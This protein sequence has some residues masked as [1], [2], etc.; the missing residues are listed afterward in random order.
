M[1]RLN[2]AFGSRSVESEELVK[3]AASDSLRPSGS[4]IGDCMGSK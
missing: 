2:K 4:V 3:G 1:L